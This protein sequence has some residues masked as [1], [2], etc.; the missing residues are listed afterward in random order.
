MKDGV[1]NNQGWIESVNGDSP[2]Q[3]K[4]YDHLATGLPETSHEDKVQVSITNL[5]SNTH[6]S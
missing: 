2:G 4:M 3:T 5:L 1:I 6:T